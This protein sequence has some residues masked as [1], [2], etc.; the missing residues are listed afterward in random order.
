M[1]ADR[2]YRAFISYSHDDRVW[3]RWLHRALESY[4]VPRRLVG[5]PTSLGST[6]R[7]LRPIFR[8]RSDLAADADLRLRID[9]ALEQSSALIVICSPSATRSPWV[10]REIRHFIRLHGEARVFG[11]IVAGWP[12]ADLVPGRETEECFPT[13]FRFHLDAAG[14]A[15]D[16]RREVIAADLRPHGDG[17]RLSRLKLAAGLL[18]LDLDDLIRRDDQQR[19]SRLSAITAVSVAGAVVMAGLT[20]EAI[21]ARDD[22]RRQ[23]AS[24]EDLVAF[25]LG[26]LK[27]NLEP[28]GRL[29]LLQS[30]VA[31]AMSY[32]DRQPAAELD[33]DAKAQHAEVLQLVGAIDEEK[34]D[35]ASATRHFDQAT[36]LTADLVRRHPRDIRRVFDQA[37]SAFYQG[38]LARRKGDDAITEASF[39]EYRRLAVTLTTM[40]PSSDRW[41]RELAYADTDL[42]ILYLDKGRT[43]A[44]LAALE[45]GLQANRTLLAHRPTDRERSRD[46]GQ[47]YAWLADA[48]LRQKNLPEVLRDRL[49]ERSLYEQ[50]LEQRP[51]DNQ[52]LEALAVNEMA[53]ANVRDLEG[54]GA[55]ALTEIGSCVE[56]YRKLLAIDPSNTTY[57]ARYTRA[58][59][60]QANY[61]LGA[62]KLA[63]AAE[64]SERA[65]VTAKRLVEIDPTA[66]SW[67]GELLG[68]A[69][70]SEILVAA[71]SAHE[72]SELHDA[73]SRATDEARRLSGLATKR[74]ADRPLA[75]V[76]AQALVMSGD[77][78]FLEGRGADARRYWIQA[79]AR[80]ER[81]G[82][83][84]DAA[85]LSDLPLI[86]QID[87]R[88]S[89]RPTMIRLGYSLK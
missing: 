15:T 4:I 87:A 1:D 33:E 8:D 86:K 54:D 89:V 37:Q 62:G 85:P 44:A 79:S 47:S 38:D 58:S 66:T 74:P 22:A 2:R 61:L 52:A 11:V 70:L 14:H 13:E 76:L 77:A 35:L 41:R 32:Y 78:E 80:L 43:D 67:Q 40:G 16:R 39:R 50:I 10:R 30:V 19:L 84:G 31:Q 56:R 65:V 68:G 88:M 69:R 48:R 63:E 21:R 82:I 53:V 9:A 42:G 25:M 46:V 20:A 60:R 72:T 27:T 23:R 81:A 64:A 24:A 7:R 75:R 34:G 3:A 5:R 18:E 6:P 45:E 12:N 83:A 36:A 73:L 51:D 17:R 29:D 26:D 55:A 49:A 57:A 28:L 71:R 59:I